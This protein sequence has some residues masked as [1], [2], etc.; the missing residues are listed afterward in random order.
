MHPDFDVKQI[1]LRAIDGHKLL[2]TIPWLV[3]YLSML[4]YVTIR[5]KY[6]R[7]LFQ[8]LQRIYLRVNV[9]NGEESLCV[10]PTSKFIVRSCLGWLFEHPVIPEDYFNQSNTRDVLKEL[11]NEDIRSLKVIV[12]PNAYLESILNAACPFLADFRVSMMPQQTTKAVSRTGRYRHITT[13]FQDKSTS[14]TARS[15]DN[16]SRLIEAF[17]ASQTIS[18]RKIVDFTIDRVTSAVIKDF[19]VEHLLRIK[20]EAKFELEEL[21]NRTSEVDLLVRKIAE[22][23]HTHLIR[24]QTTWAEEVKKNGSKR[25]QCAF[26]SLVPIETLPDVKKTLLYI[27]LERTKEKFQEWSSA[28]I[29][30]IEVFSKDIYH[31]ATKLKEKLKEDARTMTKTII[32]DLNV[33]KVPSEFFSDLQDFLYRASLQPETLNLDE[34]LNLIEAAN[35]TVEKQIFSES[36]YRNIAFYTLQVVLMCI[37]NRC[38]LVTDEALRRM[39]KLWSHEKLSS[40]T[41]KAN[42][43]NETAKRKV[44][45]F[46][47]SNVISSRLML[48]MQG[49]PRM[50]LEKYADFL[51]CLVKEKFITLEQIN[52]QSVSLYKCEWSA[53][54]LN[55]IAFLIGRVKSLLPSAASPDSQLF[56]ELVV[57]LARDMENF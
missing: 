36:G 47:F 11:L 25:V 30:T 50:N 49:K 42:S 18:V 38:D 22:T 12:E 14:H 54:S 28:N 40:F 3:E 16:R 24:L 48:T 32:V 46:V 51:V 39:L 34:L 10:L 7:E 31:E 27:T 2:V 20:K 21:A 55:D 17:L 41:I 35:E 37:A 44:S 4:D 56:M 13:K 29:A 53:Q 57:D 8:L 1:V 52:E 6:Y 15:S 9:I 43:R 45:D 5:L 19:Q 26:D 23:Y 33:T